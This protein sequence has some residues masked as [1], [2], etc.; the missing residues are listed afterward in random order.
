MLKNSC[1]PHS[2]SLAVPP[3]PAVAAMAA[4]RVT[5]RTTRPENPLA[6]I[7]AR[8]KRITPPLNCTGSSPP[9]MAQRREPSVVRVA[10]R[11][12][13]V[14]Q[15]SGDVTVHAC[16]MGQHRSGK[17]WHTPPKSNAIAMCDGPAPALGMGFGVLAAGA[18]WK[19]LKHG[20]GS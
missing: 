2:G 8:W 9:G 7:R 13:V 5:C 11:A 4:V 20:S 16:E 12:G 1:S 15:T 19:A 10:A 17:S 6:R 14:P 3:G 18:V